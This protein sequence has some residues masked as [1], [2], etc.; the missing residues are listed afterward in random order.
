MRN[1]KIAHT[2]GG[3][4]RL[5]VSAW[6]IV[7]FLLLATMFLAMWIPARAQ[8]NCPSG[9]EIYVNSGADMITV[10]SPLSNGD[11]HISRGWNSGTHSSTGKDR[12][13]LD[14]NIAGTADK[15]KAVFLPITGRVWTAYKPGT[16]TQANYG[17]TVLLWDPGSG[18]LI[19][20]AHLDSFSSVINNASGSWFG[21]GTKAGY[22]G[23]TGCLTAEC[24]PH[25]HVSA[26]RNVKIGAWTGTHSATEQEI[27]NSL[28]QGLTPA[29][30][31]PQKFRV[32]AP[33]DNC[34]LI[35]FNDGP[36][37]YTF[38]NGVYYPVTFDVWRSWG[39]SLD[40][41]PRDGQY[42]QTAGRIPL[43]VRPSYERNWYPVGTLAP[44]RT[45]SVFRGNLYPDTYVYRWGQ[46]NWLSASQFGDQPWYE[47]RWTEVQVMD[48]NF[49]DRLTPRTYR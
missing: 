10:W 39:L 11:Y 31:Q 19:R 25:L 16:T 34:D 43:R 32:T 12:Y 17:N 18:I 14:L 30:A 2:A 33:S 42:D 45:E 44:P 21:A 28:S 35:Q 24:G 41:T 6:D 1:L 27:V 26:Y 47:Y 5:R 4:M 29:F 46:K 22:I 15:G 38:K 9:I 23:V 36:T 3:I 40:L 7:R 37:V 20:L 8:I 48:Q 49:V 13:A